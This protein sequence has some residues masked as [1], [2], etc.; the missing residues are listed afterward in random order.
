M[1][2]EEESTKNMRKKADEIVKFINFDLFP[3]QLIFDAI[4]GEK[5]KE[6][7]EEKKKNKVSTVCRIHQY[8]Y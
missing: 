3:F 2:D 8:K 6:K 4:G 1:R 7:K 5:M